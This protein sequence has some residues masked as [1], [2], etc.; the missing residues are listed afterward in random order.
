MTG[1][2]EGVILKTQGLSLLG[3]R[4]LRE[5]YP[6]KLESPQESPGVELASWK[7]TDILV[8]RLA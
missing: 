8:G 3:T 5:G 4:I 1:L 6:G 2:S 7:K